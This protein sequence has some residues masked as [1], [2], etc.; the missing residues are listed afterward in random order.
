MGADEEKSL[1]NDVEESD[2]DESDDD[3]SSMLQLRPKILTET[4][5]KTPRGP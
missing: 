4:V 2:D 5:K 3:E 1:E